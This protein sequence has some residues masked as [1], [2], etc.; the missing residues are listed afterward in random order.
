MEMLEGLSLLDELWAFWR[1]MEIDQPENLPNNR[2]R[3]RRYKYS[4][5]RAYISRLK[6]SRLNYLWNL[7]FFDN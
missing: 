2:I 7:S 6:I 4:Y 5:T 1:L 3:L